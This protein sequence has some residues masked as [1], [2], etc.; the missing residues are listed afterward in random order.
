MKHIRILALNYFQ[1]K[2]MCLQRRHGRTQLQCE[3]SGVSAFLFFF[4]VNTANMSASLVSSFPFM[5]IIAQCDFEVILFKK[6]CMCKQ[7]ACK[8]FQNTCLKQSC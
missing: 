4:P 2:K 5:K 3:K 7:R 8:A 6:H 1:E